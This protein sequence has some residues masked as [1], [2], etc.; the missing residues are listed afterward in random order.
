[1]HLFSQENQIK[2]H[3]HISAISTVSSP[4]QEPRQSNPS[5]HSPTALSTQATTKY[6]GYATDVH[7]V[8]QNPLKKKHI[9]TLKNNE[10][11]YQTALTFCTNAS[12]V[13]R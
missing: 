6:D 9:R 10:C 3:I 2:E 1:L 13:T 5:P 8:L 7:S 4:L 11:G 12:Q